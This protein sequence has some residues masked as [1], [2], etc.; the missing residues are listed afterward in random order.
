[1]FVSKAQRIERS[2]AE[3]QRLQAECRE[4]V[5]LRHKKDTQKQYQTQLNALAELVERA[6]A[7]IRSALPQPDDDRS[8]DETFE[9]CRFLDQRAAWTRRLWEYFQEKFDQRDGP[10]AEVL[11]AADE[12]IWSCYRTPFDVLGSESGLKPGASPLPYIEPYLSPAAY[13][14]EIF[15]PGLTAEDRD[16]RRRFNQLPIPLVRLSPLCIR[17]PWWLIFSA[18][19]SG[20]QVQ[21]DLSL[22]DEF[23]TLLE[24]TVEGSPDGSPEV[25]ALWGEWSREIFADIY[26]VGASGPYA[27]LAMADAE[28]GTPTH[29]LDRQLDGYPAPLVRLHLLDEAAKQF[30]FERPLTSTL[31]ELKTRITKLPPEIEADLRLAPQVINAVFAKLQPN[32]LLLPDLIPPNSEFYISN[33]GNNI[34]TWAEQL[35]S[36]TS[37]MEKTLE[38]PRQLSA[39]A[40]KAWNDTLAE[41]NGNLPSEETRSAIAQR[42]LESMQKSRVDG[43]RSAKDIDN[44]SDILSDIS[45]LLV[46]SNT[47]L[48]PA[49][50]FQ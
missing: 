35:H 34:K 24:E 49:L 30:G 11:K 3:L 10:Y 42:V 47:Q 9:H 44:K 1:M 16:F 8:L 7:A 17:E 22:V 26:S 18:H 13:P 33:G 43:M 28:F 37:I 29:L 36:Q 4:W 19:E 23:R 6:C 50:K 12:V 46:S 15:P 40:Y 38:A 48:P 45:A 27:A 39:A 2:A 20:H 41:A 5:E 32:G 25:A 21:Y 14:R 31:Q